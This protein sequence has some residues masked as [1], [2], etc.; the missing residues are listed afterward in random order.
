MNTSDKLRENLVL[1]CQF[2]LG[3]AAQMPE[4]GEM[5]VNLK[6]YIGHYATITISN[7]DKP[8]LW[9]YEKDVNLTG[10]NYSSLTFYPNDTLDSIKDTIANRNPSNEF[11]RNLIVGWHKHGIKDF[12]LC[13]FEKA[14]QKANENL[15]DEDAINNFVV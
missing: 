14:V 5:D 6:S 1:I 4:T 11:M 9:I 13:E 2:L 8:K 3:K 10:R 15:E 7:K 12:I